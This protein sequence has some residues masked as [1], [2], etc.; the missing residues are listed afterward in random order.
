MTVEVEQKAVNALRDWLLL[1][2]AGRVTT[3]NATRAAV[4]KAPLVGPYTVPAGARLYHSSTDFE[5]HT[6]VN[7]PFTSGSRTAAQIATEFNAAVP[8]IAAADATGRLVFTAAAAPT[9][10]TDSLVSL[11]AD[12]TGMMAALGFDAGGESAVRSAL[13]APGVKGVMDGLPKTA[14]GGTGFWVILGDNVS[15]P[16]E[17]PTRRDEYVVGIN[18]SIHAPIPSNSDHRN[19]EHL[20]AAL[21]CVREVLF[22][23]TNGRT[24]G[25]ATGIQLVTERQALIKSRPIEYKELPNMLFGRAAIE[26]NVRVWEQQGT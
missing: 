9:E 18:C 20:R 15:L 2:L 10:G 6:T 25:N 17:P 11:G 23:E 1:K 21:R 24:L 12:A 22:L 14:D 26:L 19:R 16:V 5:T 8:G 3:V 13:V 7:P 4:L